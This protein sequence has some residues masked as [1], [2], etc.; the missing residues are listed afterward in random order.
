MNRKF[1]RVLTM[2][3]VFFLLHTQNVYAMDMIAELGR[4]AA[5]QVISLL[6]DVWSNIVGP[7]LIVIG[8]L[9]LFIKGLL[10]LMN[11]RKNAEID[12]WGLLI[13]V[14]GV[15]V[16]IVLVTVDISSFVG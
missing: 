12:K 15:I 3:F 1:T 9:Y 11:H 13:A 7:V 10:E 2:A 14:I 5:Q 4:Q 6:D 16:G 8:V